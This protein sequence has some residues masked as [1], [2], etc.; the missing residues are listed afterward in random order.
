MN[1]L[2]STFLIYLFAIHLLSSI[3]WL[4]PMTAQ[5]QYTLRTY[6]RQTDNR[7]GSS[8]HHLLTVTLADVFS[9]VLC[10]YCQL[11]LKMLHLLLSYLYSLMRS[12]NINLFFTQSFQSWMKTLV[13][14]IKLIPVSNCIRCEKIFSAWVTQA[15][16]K[17]RLRW[18]LMKFLMD[19]Q[20]VL[21]V[22]SR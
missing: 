16:C 6:N 12:S 14:H 19:A 2:Q 7:Y 20:M 15:T 18:V 4:T 9:F 5:Q 8:H 13:V 10:R 11:R 21:L 22:S 3:A 17:K 1:D